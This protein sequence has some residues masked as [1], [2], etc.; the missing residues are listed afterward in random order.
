MAFEGICRTVEHSLLL[1][2][3]RRQLGAAFGA[4]NRA[5][6]HTKSTFRTAQV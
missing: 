4:E 5:A 2:P 3:F 1:F 6:V